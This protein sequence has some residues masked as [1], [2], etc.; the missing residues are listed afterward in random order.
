MRCRRVAG[1]YDGVLIHSRG[2]SI[3][4]LDSGDRAF[5][6]EPIQ[7]RTDLETPVLIFET[8]TDMTLLG[9]TGARQDDTPTVRTWEVAGAADADSYLL[10]TVYG[11]VA[12]GIVEACN[13]LIN[14]G[15]QHQ[16]LRAALHHLVDWTRGGAA[17][18]VSPWISVRSES[19]SPLGYVVERDELGIAKGGIRTPAVDVPVS[20]LSGDPIPHSPGFCQLFGSTTPF[21]S[22]RLAEM[23]LAP[24]AYLE[25]FD[26]SLD[27][28]ISAGFVL[29][30]EGDIWRQDAAG[31]GWS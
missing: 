8:E 6:G 15:P 29:T 11:D 4:H 25:R 10:N 17:P 7:I 27:E 18:P 19:G 28:A 1:V 14:D 3:P 9:Y 31:F 12:Q 13:G 26:R 5:D 16:V 2:G 21:E 23:Y 20:T 30:P 22:A 24:A